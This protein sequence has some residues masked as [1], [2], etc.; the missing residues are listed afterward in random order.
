[1]GFEPQTIQ[2]VASHY[3][4]YAFPATKE[5]ARKSKKEKRGKNKGEKLLTSTM[6]RKL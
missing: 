3:A 5:Q 6:S 4:D 1:M 2:S